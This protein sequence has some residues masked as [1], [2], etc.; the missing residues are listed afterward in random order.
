MARPQLA[1]PPALLRSD[2]D[3]AGDVRLV[4]IGQAQIDL[5]RGFA[6]LG[7]AELQ[8]HCVVVRKGPRRGTSLAMSSSWN[9][10]NTT[11]TL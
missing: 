1:R 3:G 5:A 10:Q 8:P 4:L 11:A 2:F 6:V 9:R 7:R